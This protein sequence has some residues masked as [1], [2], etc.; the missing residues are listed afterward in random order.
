MTRTIDAC[1]Q[2]GVRSVLDELAVGE[3]AQPN[4]AAVSERIVS[5]D[6]ELQR[7][8]SDRVGSDPVALRS[9]R[10]VNEREIDLSVR[11]APHELRRADV[12]DPQRHRWVPAVKTG[13]QPGEVNLAERLDGTD[14][15]VSAQQPADGGNGVPAVLG[16]GDGTPGSRKQRPASLG[17]LDLAGAANEQVAAKFALECAN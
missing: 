11:G 1:A 12:M 9:E 8:G 10:E 5:G 16:R 15:Q 17:Q 2:R 7:F 4:A 13:E 6:G 3:V 14:R